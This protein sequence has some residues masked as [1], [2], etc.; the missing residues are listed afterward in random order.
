MSIPAIE[1]HLSPP[2]VAAGLHVDPATVLAWIKS[3]E[4]RA[5]KLGRGTKRPRYRVALSALKRLLESRETGD[6]PRQRK[7]RKPETTD[8]VAMMNLE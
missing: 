8:F 2:Q 7:R 5:R 6:K 4:L 1:Q 3:G